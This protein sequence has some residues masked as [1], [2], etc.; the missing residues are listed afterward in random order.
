MNYDYPTTIFRGIF[1]QM[2]KTFGRKI[3]IY[4]FYLGTLGQNTSEYC[5]QIIVVNVHTYGFSKVHPVSHS[6]TNGIIPG[7]NSKKTDKHAAN[8]SK[9]VCRGV[10]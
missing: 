5:S 10:K 4:K 2:Y 9:P 6:I 7:S 8:C 1:A 3:Y